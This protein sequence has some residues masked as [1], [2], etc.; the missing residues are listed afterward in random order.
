MRA[1]AMFALLPAMLLAAACSGKAGAGADDEL[2]K[3]LALAASD[4]L[5]MVPAPRSNVVSAAEIGPPVTKPTPQTRK[6][7]R[8]GVARPQRA[9][10]E[11]TV[12]EAS[13][14]AMEPTP[15]PVVVAESP[16]PAATEV[17]PIAT[18]RP[19]PIP[20][21]VPASE[22]SGGTDVGGVIGTVIGVV[23]RGGVVGD[24]HCDPRTD[25]RRRRGP[26]VGG[27]DRY[28]GTIIRGIPS[29]TDI[30]ITPM[31]PRAGAPAPRGGIAINERL[32]ERASGGR[33]ALPQRQ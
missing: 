15:A 4:G 6:A 25:G 13:Q 32:P 19:R 18:P 29:P 16:A 26:R 20:I 1:T 17:E 11:P 30:P 22:P 27:T 24:D 14:V 33:M 28:P 21:G 5:G 9:V 10:V 31:V 12:A 3:D 23:I 8:K 7:P 2:A